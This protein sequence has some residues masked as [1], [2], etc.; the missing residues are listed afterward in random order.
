MTEVLVLCYH[1]VSPTWNA[2]LSVTPDALEAQLSR[3]SRRGWRG[4]TF[5]QAVLDPP[6]PRTLVVTF[7]DAFLSVLTRARPILSELGLPGTVF[8]PTAFA[9]K[10]QKLLWSGV[11]QW[12]ETEHAHE[13]DGMS[14]DDLAVLDSDGW[15]VASHTRSHPRLTRL[16]DPTLRFELEE[17]RRECA[18]RLRRPCDTLAYPYGD[19][20]ERVVHFARAAGYKAA[21]TLSSS[22]RRA[23]AH[24]WPRVGIYHTDPM[25][26][27]GLKVNPTVR[28]L[29]ASRI[30][31]AHE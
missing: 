13:L 10:R 1:A 11:E 2:A 21:A 17:S 20:D 9:A 30:W 28:R 4:A 7:D 12:S 18:E 14:W 5:R 23:G 24:R 19:T 22:L 16:D 25:W 8:A 3:L 31:P 6:W 26:R 27:F 29:R 15:E